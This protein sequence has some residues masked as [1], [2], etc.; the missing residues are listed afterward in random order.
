[1]IRLALGLVPEHG[2]C[3]MRVHVF[4]LVV[5][6]AASLLLTAAG[7]DQEARSVTP[8]QG[9]VTY[10]GTPV[11]T[12]LIVFTPDAHRGGNGPLARAPIR[13]D[14]TYRLW[15]GDRDGAVPG[16]YRVTVVAVEAPA[17]SMAGGRLVAPRSLL[18]EKYQAPES[19]ELVREVHAGRENWI[20]F[21]LE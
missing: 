21:N 9:R 19:S 3:V 5:A 2:G 16:W 14:G 6:S 18:P 1:M 4:P 15:T 10:R 8:V 11:R 13:H 12:G 20:D 17:A 7:C